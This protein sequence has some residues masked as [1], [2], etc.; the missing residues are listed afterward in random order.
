MIEEEPSPES[1]RDVSAEDFLFHLYRGSELL[2]DDRVHE[3]KQELEQALSLQPRDAKGQDL[4]AIVYFRLGLYPRAISI[5]E[6]LI[7]QYPEATT[8]RINLALCY[9]KTGQPARARTELEE[10]IRTD[11]SHG[12]AW[13]YLGLSFQRMG[14]V[15]RA[16]AAFQAGGHHHMAKRLVPPPASPSNPTNAPPPQRQLSDTEREAVSRVSGE[17]F[18]EIDREGVQPFKTELSTHLRDRPNGTWAATEPGRASPVDARPSLG[19]SLT[20]SISA[21]DDLAATAEN[22]IYQAA[23]SPPPPSMREPP[24]RPLEHRTLVPP[25]AVLARGTANDAFFSDRS[26]LSSSPPAS[27][28]DFARE[29]LLVFPRDH[30]TALHQTGCV[31]IQ[32]GGELAVRFDAVRAM[33]FARGVVTKPLPKRLRGRETEEPLGSAASPLM[34][35]EGAGQLVL[36]PPA[37]T[38]LVP[39]KLAGEP[40]CVRETSLIALDGQLTYENARLPG[41]D[42]DF[43]S[44]VQLRGTGT[45]T[46]ALPVQTVT[47]ELAEDRTV[48]VRIHSVLGW[49]GRIAPRAVL[50]SEAPVKT[51]GLVALTGEG[52]VLVDGR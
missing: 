8:P 3:A 13:G 33:T 20:P 28:V 22:A 26:P 21:I 37:G 36:G 41:G 45:V 24:I 1:I 35:V 10:V 47:F 6:G 5:F 14:D 15:E 25:D 32:G 16:V 42:G 39:V 46:I 2:Q 29:Q 52:M 40:L 44:M 4:L 18:D 9:L 50:P 51:R 7:A 12:R 43:V 38:R 48:N 17:A 31:L 23:T 49:T 27:A 34:S 11:P 30:S 19:L